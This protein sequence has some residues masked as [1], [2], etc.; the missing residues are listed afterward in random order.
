[1]KTKTKKTEAQP[2]I[3]TAEDFHRQ[4]VGAKE[5]AE[6]FGVD[7]SRIRQICIANN[8]GWLFGQTRVVPRTSIP[9]IQALCLRARKKI[10]NVG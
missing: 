4:F 7:E 1:M 5:L 2:E 10:Q 9:E 8:I 6:M 3:C